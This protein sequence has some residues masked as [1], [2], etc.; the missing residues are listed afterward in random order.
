MGSL[1]HIRIATVPA[2]GPTSS[3]FRRS[4]PFRRP[5]SLDNWMGSL[6]LSHFGR[7]LYAFLDTN[8]T[9]MGC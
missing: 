4:N 6:G 5:V 8:C 1:E 7:I 9:H 3:A 2:Q